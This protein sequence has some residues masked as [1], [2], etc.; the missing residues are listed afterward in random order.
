MPKKKST[1]VPRTV[2]LCYIRLSY[3]RDENDKD[4][5]E[6]Q[7]ANIQINVSVGVGPRSGIPIQ[8]VTSQAKVKRIALAG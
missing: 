7:R 1:A 3:T 6:R 5:P 4:S 8:K 2:A